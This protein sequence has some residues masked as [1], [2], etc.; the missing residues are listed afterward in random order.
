M[1]KILALSAGRKQG[2]SE[3]LVKEA[4][5]VTQE[6][7]GAEVALIRLSELNIHDCTGCEGCMKSLISGGEGK[8]VLKGDDLDWLLQRLLEADGFILGTPIYDL[9]PCGKLITM[10]N[11]A[12][13][14]GKAHRDACRAKPKVAAALSV[15]GSDWI[16]LAEPLIQITL[17]NLL[18][19]CEV[20]DRLVVGG[21]T[22]PGMVL[23]DDELL[24]RSRCLGR[25]VAEGVVHLDKAVWQGKDGVCPVCHCDLIVPTGGMKAKCPFCGVSGVLEVDG[26]N[27][28][29]R[30]DPET[31]VCQRFVPA[32][33]VAHQADIRKAHAKAKAGAELLRQRK[34]ERKTFDPVIRP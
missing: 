17:T 14:A 29:F 18:K 6:E 1:M 28:L 4:L 5:R 22:A 31:V 34:E 10:L 16:D 24:E 19:D 27:L 33:E 12:L 3:M 20:V 26:G 25:R 11:R 13:G 7:Y 9:I 21:N 32:G 8:C 2:N 23:L 15:G 30:P